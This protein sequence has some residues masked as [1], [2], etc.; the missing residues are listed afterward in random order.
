M[1]KLLTHI[2]VGIDDEPMFMTGSQWGWLRDGAFGIIEQYHLHA[3]STED[4]ILFDAVIHPR[5]VQIRGM[6]L[7]E[8]VKRIAGQLKE[9]LDSVQYPADLSDDSRQQ[10]IS[11]LTLLATDFNRSLIITR[12]AVNPW[13]K[14]IGIED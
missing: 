1:S 3:A 6:V 4:C 8:D 11:M 12:D 13:G 7:K 14:F 10:T 5:V 9:L 2:I